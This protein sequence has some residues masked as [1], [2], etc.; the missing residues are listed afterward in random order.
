MKK[1]LIA[2]GIPYVF[3]LTDSGGST[4]LSEGTERYI[5]DK[6]RWQAEDVVFEINGQTE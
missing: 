1:V 6:H 5:P 2:L 4:K 3:D